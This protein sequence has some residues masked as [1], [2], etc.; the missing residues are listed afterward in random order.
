MGRDGAERG[1]VWKCSR[2][3]V[4]ARLYFS[5]LPCT[6]NAF[7]FFFGRGASVNGNA[8]TLP[9]SRPDVLGC[10]PP[11]LWVKS[12]PSLHP[13][14]FPPSCYTDLKSGNFRGLAASGSAY[15]LEGIWSWLE[16][17]L[18]HQICS[19]TRVQLS[20]LNTCNK[21]CRV[22]YTS[23]VFIERS[24]FSFF[25]APFMGVRKLSH[26]S[27]CKVNIPL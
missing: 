11:P 5:L 3:V 6:V 10:R 12:P 18:K 2:E 21:L 19:W 26:V 25:C 20:N 15:L 1:C 24:F 13:T 23:D 17:V 8:C 14:S 7:F 9:G 4:E 22:G 16:K 27:L